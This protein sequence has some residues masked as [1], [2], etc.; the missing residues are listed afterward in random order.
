MKLGPFDLDPD[1]LVVI[2]SD[3]NIH[4]NM[5]FEIEIFIIPIKVNSC[6]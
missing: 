1:I 4:V 3:D 5:M 2:R 6:S